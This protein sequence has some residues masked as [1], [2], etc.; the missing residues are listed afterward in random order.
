MS[1]NKKQS[2]KTNQR[3]KQKVAS[4]PITNRFQ[5][6]WKDRS[7]LLRFLGV[8]ILLMSA[9]YLFYFSPI[10]A[11]YIHPPILGAQAAIGAFLIGLFESS[12]EAVGS[13]IRTNDFSMNI[14]GGCDGLEV[15]ALFVAGVIAFP[16]TWKEKWKGLGVGLTVL[17]ILNILRFPILYWAGSK[18]SEELFDF[19]HI[20]G[21]FI[22]FIS[23]SILMWGLW[24]IRIENERKGIL[25]N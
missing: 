13:I 15:T 4:P 19:L 2:K 25:S 22:L 24:I 5:S 14:S 17:T 8:F 21:G 11:K 9:F 6:W 12:A 7:F 20:Q 3:K 10:N 18:V 16:S 23:I 1:K